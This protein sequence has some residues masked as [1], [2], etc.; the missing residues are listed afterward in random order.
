[1]L[2]AVRLIVLV[3]FSAA[4]QVVV[5]PAYQQV[6][7]RHAL[8]YEG[9]RAKGFVLR[10]D[11]VYRAGA[12]GEAQGQEVSPQELEAL[13]SGKG[14]AAERIEAR[15][16][17]LAALGA[18]LDPSRLNAGQIFDGAVA[19]GAAAVATA[20][21]LGAAVPAA[22]PIPAAAATPPSES[23]LALSSPQPYKEPPC[24]PALKPLARDLWSAKRRARALRGLENRFQP[25]EDS[26]TGLSPQAPEALRLVAAAV[27]E[28]K[29]GPEAPAV[30]RRMLARV[31]GL[32]PD[33]KDAFVAGINSPLAAYVIL[34]RSRA[35]HAYESRLYF[36]RMVELLDGRRLTDFVREQDPAGKTST[37]FF[38]RVHAYDSLI[39]YLNQKPAEAAALAEFLFPDGPTRALRERAAQ[40]EGLMTQLAVQGRRSGALDSFV[41]GLEG[42]AAASSPGLAR[43]I[44]LYLQINE[45]LLPKRLRADVESLAGRFPSGLLDDAGLAPSDPHD[46]WP[47]DHWRF[48]L[49]FASTSSYKGWLSSFLALGYQREP[50]EDGL[51]VSKHFDGP[52]PGL[53]GLTVTVHATLYPGDKE[54]FLRGAEAKRFLAAV[55]R[56]LRDPDIQG[57]ILRNH[58]QFR[59]ANLIGKSVT[60]GKLLIDGACRSAWDLQDLRRKCPTCRFVVNT[61]T[62]YGAIT[63]DAAVAVIEG[64]ARGDGWE[65]I[66]EAW[67]R[68][69]P[70]S[71]ARI[72]GPWT[73]AFDEALRLLDKQEAPATRG[74]GR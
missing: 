68:K 48:A 13:L 72:Q 57:V 20:E 32:D 40:L 66:G 38:L 35:P 36:Q 7:A 12:G 16:P 71:S 53:G 49:H 63:N 4:A 65:E 27:H 14:P 28:G 64:L 25:D 37:N 59:I 33:Q 54:G 39:P 62:G 58:A 61:G 67:Q 24:D 43:R 2:A 34:G 50:A 22:A 23:S 45:A 5:P 56:D 44:A 17:A 9:L 11:R 47:A 41:L 21:T 51:E 52:D 74:M 55:S 30:L 26:D 1:M 73:P 10:Q 19:P 42:L 3:V 69:N 8:D 29:G 18:R 31:A 15:Q 70:R 6:L 46:D 60:P